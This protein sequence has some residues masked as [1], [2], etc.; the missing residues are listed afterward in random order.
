MQEEKCCGG[1]L[2]P[3]HFIHN[4]LKFF[5]PEL[6]KMSLFSVLHYLIYL[7]FHKGHNTL[8]RKVKNTLN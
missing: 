5:S 7:L 8:V 6:T 2:T 1:N 3:D 4:V